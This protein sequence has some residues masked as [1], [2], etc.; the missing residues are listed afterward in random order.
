MTMRRGFMRSLP[1][2]SEKIETVVGDAVV[3]TNHG[4]VNA[5][6]RCVMCEGALIELL[7]P[8]EGMA[9]RVGIVDDKG[10]IFHSAV[11]EGARLLWCRTCEVPWVVL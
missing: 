10:V 6:D 2:D 5:A 8:H 3:V 4:M 7:R 1:L 11:P 9:G